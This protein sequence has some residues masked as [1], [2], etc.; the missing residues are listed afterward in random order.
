MFTTPRRRSTR[1]YALCAAV[2][3]TGFALVG[4]LTRGTA[5]APL[6]APSSFTPDEAIKQITGTD[7]ALR[8]DVAENAIGYAWAGDPPLTDGL[9]ARRT[10]FLTQGYIYP[11]GTLTAENGV[12]PDGAPEFPDKVLGQWS[13]WGWFL[14]ADAPAGTARWLTTHLVNLGGAWGEATLVSEGYSIDEPEVAL[15]RA[16]VGGT[17]PYAGARGVQM[18]TNL[19][20][21]A[22]NGIN[23]RYE[24]RLTGE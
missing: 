1:L 20:F 14:G 3:L 17:G 24:V 15:P 4:N 18:E 19:G 2:V 13:C 9:P 22:S 10:A 12:L 23:V 5:S 8:F 7:G 16:I 6:A 11:A 21:N